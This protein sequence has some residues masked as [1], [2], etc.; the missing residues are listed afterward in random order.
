MSKQGSH[1][2]DKDVK[3][4]RKKVSKKK[5]KKFVVEYRYKSNTPRWAI[6]KK[7]SK[8]FGYTNEK[9]RDEALK[10]LNKNNCEFGLIE[11]R[12]R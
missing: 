3:I 6:P 11:F 1:F 10:A 7:W 5:A 4:T 12:K 8:W 9:S 2:P